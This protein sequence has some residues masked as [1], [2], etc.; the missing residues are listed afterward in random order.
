MVVN[1]LTEYIGPPN[2]VYY[3]VAISSWRRSPISIEHVYV[4]YVLFDLHQTTYQSYQGVYSRKQAIY[5]HVPYN[6]SWGGG[7][8]FLLV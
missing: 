4:W 7:E 3:P 1:L 5:V 2:C 8:N 6:K